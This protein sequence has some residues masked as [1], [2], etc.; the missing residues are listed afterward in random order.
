MLLPNPDYSKTI[1]HGLFAAFQMMFAVITPALI[2]G[3]FVERVRF[4]SFLLFSLLWATLVY[5]PL[6]PLGLGTGRLAE[7]IWAYWIL[8]A[9]RWFTSQPV[10]RPWPLRW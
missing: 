1:P 10:S 9:E 4:K 6:V 2:T 8:P 3:A 7:T 5:D